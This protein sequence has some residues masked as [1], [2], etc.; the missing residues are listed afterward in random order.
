[1]PDLGLALSSEEHRPLDLVRYAQRAEEA[2]FDFL[3]ISDHYHPWVDA[4]GESPFVWAVI[5]GIAART[6]RI[7]LGTGVTCPI[8]RIHPAVLAQ[9][10][11]TAAA[12][13]PGRFFFGVGTGEA[14]N[15]HVTGQH[16]PPIDVRLEMLEEAV[17]VMRGLWEGELYSHHGRHFT[18]ENA[19][20]YTLPDVPPPVIVAASG[21]KAATL[22][23]RIGDGFW[24]TT[25]DADVLR[26]F[27]QNGGQGPR[28]GQVTV[29]YGDDTDKCRALASE[30]WPN[31]GFTGQ[32]SQELP[33]PSLFEAAVEKVP[34]EVL[35]S[36][37]PCG[38]DPQPYVE[39]IQAYLDAGFDSVYLHQ[40]GPDQD[41]A[42]DFFAREVFPAIRDH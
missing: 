13:L 29:C 2:G 31:A 17:E 21:E 6:E 4:Q 42:I 39:A 23:G 28:Y 36:S 35:T 11:A 12:M 16:W 37:M 19:R 1:M 33:L 3:S 24:N 22:A 10:A 7:R 32:L 18:V 9:A 27:E 25:P 15:E 5:G 14:L 30:V 38:P 8:L 41:S 20:I 40:V 26:V 34:A